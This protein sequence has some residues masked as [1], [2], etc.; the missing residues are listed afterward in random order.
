MAT[1]GRKP[2]PAKNRT[3]TPP[4]DSA[5]LDGF[6]PEKKGGLTKA[7]ERKAKMEKQ[8]QEHLLRTSQRELS[9]LEGQLRDTKE[10]LGVGDDDLE[11]AA[12]DAKSAYEMLQ[13]MRYAYKTA[14][15]PGGL[16][17][18]KRLVQLAKSDSE[19]KLI[20]KELLR[21]ESALKQ[22]EI[23]G[24]GGRGGEGG[25]NTQNFFVVL[26]GLETVDAVMQ[27]AG[28][29]D[30]TLDMKQISHAI[31]PEEIGSYDLEEEESRNAEPEQ[32]LGAGGIGGGWGMWR[33]W[34]LSFWKLF[35]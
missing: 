35:Q 13:D 1:R 32:L 15:G 16:K 27:M 24:S 5:I 22:A 8:R 21:I 34:S 10:K 11:T 17:G 7:D 28:N 19:F 18:R 33:M 6:N 30:K 9:K 3:G 31:S 2:G 20:V 14:V 4:K 23:R 26:K 25:A 12:D 29:K